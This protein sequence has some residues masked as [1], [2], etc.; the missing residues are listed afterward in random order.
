MFLSEIFIDRKIG[1]LDVTSL[2]IFAFNIKHYGV[3]KEHPPPH[4]SP[5]FS[6]ICLEVLPLY[7]IHLD[8]SYPN[9]HNRSQLL[10]CLYSFFYTAP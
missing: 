6:N 7:F 5:H 4:H 10:D 2:I 9:P 1:Y 8:A 3:F